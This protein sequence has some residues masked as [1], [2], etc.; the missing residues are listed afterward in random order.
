M[1]IIRN[2]VVGQ[3]LEELRRR[4]HLTQHAVPI[5]MGYSQSLVRKVESGD[6]GVPFVELWSYARAIDMSADDLLDELHDSL[7]A[8]DL[9]P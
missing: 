2:K 8:A 3:R 9:E 6:R 4:R 7:I 5:R 1:D